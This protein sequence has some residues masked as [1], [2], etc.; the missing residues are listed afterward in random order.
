ML[1]CHTRRPHS[2]AAAAHFAKKI[3]AHK[4]TR[5]YGQRQQQ[6][7]A[8]PNQPYQQQ[9]KIPLD[10]ACV[11]V[12]SCCLDKQL[13]S[14]CHFRWLL[15]GSVVESV[16]LFIRPPPMKQQLRQ[17]TAHTTAQ[18][19]GYNASVIYSFIGGGR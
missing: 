14:G 6:P 4:K 1:L 15:D 12:C 5:L 11:S 16:R 2:T 18:C 8:S 17:P 13:E 19:E 9:C 7:I 10:D 3:P